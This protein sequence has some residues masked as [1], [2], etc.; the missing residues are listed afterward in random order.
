MADTLYE[1][2]RQVPDYRKGNAIRHNLED[3]LMIGLLSGICNGNTNVDMAIF[4]ETHEK[5]LQ[6]FL[7]LPYGIPS[8]DTYEEIYSKLEPKK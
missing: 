1:M 6:E 4:G 3:V 5:E 8:V 2:L 7:E